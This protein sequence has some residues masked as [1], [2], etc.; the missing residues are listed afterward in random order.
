MTPTYALKNGVRYR[1]YI[2]TS[3]MQSRETSKALV[4][5]IA[6]EVVETIVVDAL[7]QGQRTAD[8]TDDSPTARDRAIANSDESSCLDRRVPG[9][10]AER[11]A[12]ELVHSDLPG[13]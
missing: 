8:R 6:A 1:Y 12:R 9:A 7:S 2:S 4:H 11:R 3:A 5:R 10:E 13:G